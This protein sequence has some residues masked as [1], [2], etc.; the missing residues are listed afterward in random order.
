MLVPV[1]VSE[2]LFEKAHIL[3]SGEVEISEAKAIRDLEEVQCD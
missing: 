3:R 2:S 1:S